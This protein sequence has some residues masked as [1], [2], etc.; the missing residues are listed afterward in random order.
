MIEDCRE[1]IRRHS[2]PL[3]PIPTG[4]EPLLRLGS[5]LDVDVLLVPHHGSSRQAP[6]FLAS[7]T[8][9]VAL[10]S[11]GAQND[12]GHPTKKTLALVGQLTPNLVRTDQHGAIAV[13]SVGGHLVVTT[14]K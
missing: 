10:I 5:L 2:S 12:Y 8:P 11:V 6:A 3:S 7:T 13:A 14:Q 1:I 4:Q 9:Q